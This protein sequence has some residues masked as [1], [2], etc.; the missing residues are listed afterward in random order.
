[1]KKRT[2]LY[3]DAELLE[4]AKRKFNLSQLLEWAIIKAL[5]GELEELSPA[6]RP[7]PEGV[8]GF[9]SRPPHSFS[10][11]ELF[12]EFVKHSRFASQHSF[13]T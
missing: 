3:I 2:S 1:M 5:N 10:V 6:L 13:L 9:K 4:K 11:L 8:R 7:C 12:D